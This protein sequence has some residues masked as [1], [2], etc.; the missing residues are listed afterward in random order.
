MLVIFRKRVL[1]LVNTIAGSHFV[2]T[3]NNPQCGTKSCLISRFVVR[4]ACKFA[5]YGEIRHDFVP[6][7]GAVVCHDKMAALQLSCLASDSLP[8]SFCCLT[9]IVQKF[10]RH[11]TFVKLK[12]NS[13]LK[14]LH[15]ADQARLAKRRRCTS[16]DPPKVSVFKSLLFEVS[17][18]AG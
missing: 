6:H 7:C 16:Q 3:H 10:I 14:M 15:L 9:S 18:C 2:A 17:V 8:D 12:K 1:M 4:F 13:I 5:V 11:I